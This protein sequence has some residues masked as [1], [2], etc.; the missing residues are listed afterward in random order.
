M[1]SSAF[2]GDAPATRR[3]LREREA[4]AR[5]VPGRTG[6]QSVRPA[7]RRTPRA[8]G[9]QALTF[10]T[11]TF[12]MLLA[13]GMSIPANAFGTAQAATAP[14]TAKASHAAQTL[15]VS[16]ADSTTPDARGNLSV[17]MPRI[18]QAIASGLGEPTVPGILVIPAPGPLRWPTDVSP[19]IGRGVSAAHHGQDLLVPGGTPVHA[20]ADGTVLVSAVEGG[21]GQYVVIQS[22]VGGHVVTSLYAHMGIGS[23]KVST[24]ETVTQGQVIGAVGSSGAA[25]GF[26]L[27]LR[28]LQDGELCD[29]VTYIAGNP[30]GGAAPHR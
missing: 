29:T 13:I 19:H 10:A 15:S 22:N 12:V 26:V 8:R 6:R 28:I 24:G 20:I 7:P 23:Q 3:E 5:A 17:T 14:R 11:M 30:A 2:S 16:E 25:T 27:Y 9:R 1:G 4:A 21:Y 18:E